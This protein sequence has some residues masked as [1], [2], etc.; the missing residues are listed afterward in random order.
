M[1]WRNPKYA[2]GEEVLH[3]CTPAVVRSIRMPQVGT[4][5]LYDIEYTR[6]GWK[7]CRHLVAEEALAP[8][9]APDLTPDPT[10]A[11]GLCA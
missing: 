2:H 8:L 10:P 9:P 4:A 7:G 1:T 3:G 5:I 11:G 6:G